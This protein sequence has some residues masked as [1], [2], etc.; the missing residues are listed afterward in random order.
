[1]VFTALSVIVKLIAVGSIADADYYD[2]DWM[3]RVDNLKTHEPIW[4]TG[5][6]TASLIWFWSE[7]IVMLLNKRRRAL[8]DFIA[9][10][11]VIA[12]PSQ[13]GIPNADAVSTA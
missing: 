3:K 10:T 11:I 13:P 7:F 8:H 5:V 1:M 12:E 9:G 6:E 4:A 2:V